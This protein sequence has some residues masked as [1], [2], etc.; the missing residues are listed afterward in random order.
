LEGTSQAKPIKTKKEKKNVL[1]L[2]LAQQ[3]QKLGKVGNVE[4]FAEWLLEWE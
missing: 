1:G 4:M 2:D 3:A